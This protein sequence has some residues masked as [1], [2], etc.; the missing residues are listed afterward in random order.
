MICNDPE[1]AKHDAALRE[2]MLGKLTALIDGT[3]ALSD[4]GHGAGL[5]SDAIWSRSALVSISDHTCSIRPSRK[6]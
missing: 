4:S 2:V 6:R 5:A 3:D 1:Q